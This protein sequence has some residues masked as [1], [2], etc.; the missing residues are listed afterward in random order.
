[1]KKKV[2]LKLL[3]KT[4]V[5]PFFFA[6]LFVWICYAVFDELKAIQFLL[7]FSLMLLFGIGA[8]L[9]LERRRKEKEEKAVKENETAQ[10]IED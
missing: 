1:M 8:A 7:Q 6:Q 4:I 9:I 2:N 3:L 5:L 10:K